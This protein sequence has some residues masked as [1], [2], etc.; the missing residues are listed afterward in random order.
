MDDNISS[1]LT[2]NEIPDEIWENIVCFLSMKY[3]LILSEVSRK[4]YNIAHKITYFKQYFKKLNT[5]TYL[6]FNKISYNSFKTMKYINKWHNIP[7][8]FKLNKFNLPMIGIENLLK[9]YIPQFKNIIKI[10]YDNIYDIQVSRINNNFKIIVPKQIKNIYLYFPI[11]PDTQI[12]D[13]NQLIHSNYDYEKYNNIQILIISNMYFDF[14][15]LLKFR[16][17]KIL[18]IDYIPV[19]NNTIKEFLSNIDT[20]KLYICPDIEDY[21]FLKNNRCIVHTYTRLKSS[22]I[23]EYNNCEKISLLLY[24]ENNI[25]ISS[26]K[27][28]K[29]LN[30]LKIYGMCFNSLNG[31]ENIYKIIA[32]DTNINN[33]VNMMFCNI[34]DLSNT[35]IKNEDLDK[36]INVEKLK[37]S[38]CKNINNVNIFGIDNIKSKVK[39]LDI[40][41]NQ[42]LL[43]I[44][45]LYNLNELNIIGLQ[46]DLIYISN[47][48]NKFDNT[49]IYDKICLCDS[50][51][52]LLP[53]KYRYYYE[54]KKSTIDLNK[55][56]YI[57]TFN[58][59]DYL[60]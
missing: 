33:L 19:I 7:I 21:S 2:I 6:T 20:L 47:N 59:F 25:D 37:I 43:D 31:L 54:S 13:N 53:P 40:S 11:I 27:N 3:L 44:N 52:Q 39:V 8:S 57:E 48:M 32:N 9:N 35:K 41:F 18:K 4:Y 17:L 16:N 30:S 23:L 10:D 50:C 28:N 58:W 14:N 55:C 56:K 36:L 46:T 5:S 51:F 24:T 45:N 49:I 15:N 34:V 38:N 1:K 26:L 22:D 29:K 12:Q 60:V 42:E